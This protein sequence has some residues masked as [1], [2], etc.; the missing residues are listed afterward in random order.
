MYEEMIRLNMDGIVFY[1]ICSDPYDFN[2]KFYG[3]YTKEEFKNVKCYPKSN[4]AYYKKSDSSRF[5]YDSCGEIIKPFLR[6]NKMDR[7]E[8]LKEQRDKI[9]HE[10]KILE[11]K[12]EDDKLQEAKDKYVGKYFIYKKAYQSEYIY[13]T[14]IRKYYLV[15]GI[16]V[17]TDMDCY[18]C[19]SPEEIHIK[20]LEEITKEEYDKAVDFVHELIG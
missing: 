17:E 14:D 5:F 18:W 20:Y 10:I 15:Y 12:K 2:C 3:D 1:T 8:E 19:I 9:L 6:D 13:V 4:W 11:M 7:L 16:V